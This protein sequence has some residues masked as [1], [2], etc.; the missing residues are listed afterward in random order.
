MRAGNQTTQNFRPSNVF[1]FRTGNTTMSP[2]RLADLLGVDMNTQSS[3]SN[4]TQRSSQASNPTQ[5]S[6]QGS[7]RPT[8]WMP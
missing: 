6:T 3:T 7:I 1:N 5:R 8:R 4:P 2:S